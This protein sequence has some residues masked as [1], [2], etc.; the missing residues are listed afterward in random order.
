MCSLQF[1]VL[2]FPDL[3]LRSCICPQKHGHFSDMDGTIQNIYTAQ[4]LDFK[5]MMYFPAFQA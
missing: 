3:T 4:Q 5:G 1:V 2:G